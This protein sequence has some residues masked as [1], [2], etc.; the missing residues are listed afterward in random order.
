MLFEDWAAS[1]AGQKK[2]QEVIWIKII[3]TPIIIT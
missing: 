1:R 2:Q 3:N